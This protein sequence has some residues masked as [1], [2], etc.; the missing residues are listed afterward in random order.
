MKKN[1]SNYQF[2][3]SAEAAAS[4]YL[5]QRDYIILTQNYRTR[6]GEIDLV[7]KHDDYLIFVE[8]KSSRDEHG[9]FLGDRV[10]IRKQRRIYLTAL[11]YIQHHERPGG[12]IRFDVILLTATPNKEWK[13]QHIQDAF[14]LDDIPDTY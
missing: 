11:D 10:D 6:R 1:T 13:V 4:A 3:I 8:V 9:S 7:C 14:R 12:G 5:K 2:G